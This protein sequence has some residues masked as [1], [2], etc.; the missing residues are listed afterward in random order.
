MNDAQHRPD[1]RESGPGFLVLASLAESPKPMH[2]MIEDI[3]QIAGVRLSPDSL[4]AAVARLAQRGLVEPLVTDDRRQLY[5]L[6]D[7][8]AE[9][10]RARFMHLADLASARAFTGWKTCLRTCLQPGEQLQ[11]PVRGSYEGSLTYRQA[12]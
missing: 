5:W 6:T 12:A 1:D 10:A 11:D 4:R 7:S 9:T 8:G 3:E 2:G